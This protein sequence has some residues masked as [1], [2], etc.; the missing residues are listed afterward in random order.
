MTQLIDF[1]AIA[2]AVFVVSGAT[3]STLAGVLAGCG[4]AAYGLWCYRDGAR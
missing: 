4:V 2:V 3:G 1:I